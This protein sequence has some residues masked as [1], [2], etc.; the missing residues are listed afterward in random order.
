MIMQYLALQ[1]TW[2]LHFHPKII[3]KRWPLLR[4]TFVARVQR[5]INWFM[6]ENRWCTRTVISGQDHLS[7]DQVNCDLIWTGA[8]PS[9]VG[10]F[11]RVYQSVGSD[12]IAQ[13]TCF[14]ARMPMLFGL[15]LSFE[16][17]ILV[18]VV[19]LVSTLFSPYFP[20]CFPFGL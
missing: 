20:F 19:A 16:S 1:T 6:K 5:W 8:Q 7:L 3:Q 4:K 15:A 9:G 12:L 11:D 2:Q 17:F 10:A 14:R 18:V 13:Q